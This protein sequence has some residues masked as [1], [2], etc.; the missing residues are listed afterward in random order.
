[1]KCEENL[2]HY[3]RYDEIDLCQ[4]DEHKMHLANNQSYYGAIL[5]GVNNNGVHFRWERFH[6]GVDALFYSEC[7][8]L[9]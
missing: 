9:F 6:I 3:M 5:F 7:M 4:N 2:S 1:M 8:L